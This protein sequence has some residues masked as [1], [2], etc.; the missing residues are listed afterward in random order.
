ML[1]VLLGTMILFWG[2]TFHTLATTKKKRGGEEL[3]TRTKVFFLGKDGPL[4]PNYEQLL[5]EVTIFRQ[6]CCSMLPNY[7]LNFSIVLFEI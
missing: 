1:F 4:L 3:V 5:F 7:S 2:A 6:I